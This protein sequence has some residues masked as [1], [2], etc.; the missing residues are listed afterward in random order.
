MSTTKQSH[1]MTGYIDVTSMSNKEAGTLAGPAIDKLRDLYFLPSHKIPTNNLDFGYRLIRT[2]MIPGYLASR[3]FPLA[4]CVFP[5][6]DG[7]KKEIVAFFTA[8]LTTKSSVCSYVPDQQSLATHRFDPY[9]MVAWIRE[10]A[11][12]PWE[13]PILCVDWVVSKVKDH[14]TVDNLGPQEII[15]RVPESYLDLQ[16]ALLGKGFIAESFKHSTKKLSFCLILP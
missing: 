8:S 6:T 5:N 12:D 11:H 10:F 4:S 3:I 14:R 15:W 16:R 13:N 9:M 7:E 1:Y 2:T